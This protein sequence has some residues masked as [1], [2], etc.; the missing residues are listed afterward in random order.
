MAHFDYPTPFFLEQGSERLFALFYEPVGF[1]A[2][3]AILLAPP[4]GD[5]M[6]KSRRMITL[7]AQAFQQQGYAVLVVDLVGT[8]DSSGE[9]GEATWERWRNNLHAAWQWLV[10]EQGLS[11][12][13]LW[14]IRLGALLALDTASHF[15]LSVASFLFWQPVSNGERFVTQLL[16]LRQ[17]EQFGQKTQETVKELRAQSDAG[18]PLEIGGY[19]VNAPLIQAISSLRV[20]DFVPIQGPVVWLECSTAEPAELLPASHKLIEDWH[21]AGGTIQSAAVTGPAFWNSVEIEEVPELIEQTVVL[22]VGANHG[23]A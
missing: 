22:F 21:A 16:R 9:F 15:N 5:E 18:S 13:H 19:A 23:P 8:G 1:R 11:C 7:Q 6:N 3:A 10:Q 12:I 17:A 20:A 4:F 2:S 14:G